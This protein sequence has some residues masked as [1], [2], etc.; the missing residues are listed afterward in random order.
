MN[1]FMR[2]T[3]GFSGLLTAIGVLAP[4]SARAQGLES[5]G[6]IHVEANAECVVVPPSAQCE[7]MCEPI[8]VEA[9]CAARLAADCR[10]RC[11]ELP[12]VDCSASCQADCSADCEV[13]PGKFDCAASCRADCSGSCAASCEG[14]EDGGKCM[15]RCEGSC[16]ASCDSHCDVDLPE[17]DCEAKC[18]ASCEGS[19]EVDTNVDCQADCQAEA[20]ADCYVDV[21]GGCEAA[22]DTEEGALFCDGQYVDHGNNLEEC[23]AAL[24]AAL[25]IEVEGHA[26]GE[27]SC[28]NG[29]CMAMGEAEVS[30][31][32]SVAEPGAGRSRWAWSVAGLALV[33]LCVRRR[34][35]PHG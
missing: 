18:E 33:G 12:S 6:D 3:L 13:D 15:A 24:E 9:A 32:C 35:Q 1:T 21:Q 4:M 29:R 20:E 19:C 34:R 5:C 8:T 17:V 31:D 28:D 11:D 22:C 25:D 2:I 7:A 10:A 14:D 27:S 30:S 26:H 16:G 23:A